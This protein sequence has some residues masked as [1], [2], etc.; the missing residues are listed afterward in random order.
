[1][2]KSRA[3][4]QRAKEHDRIIGT[5]LR[6]MRLAAGMSQGDLGEAL[7]VTFQQ[8]QKY[9][10]GVNRVSGSALLTLC[11]VLKTTPD[12]LLGAKLNGKVSNS[13]TAVDLLDDPAIYRALEAL[14]ALPAER[15]S[16]V[17]RAMMALTAAF[18]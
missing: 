13:I 14:R 7:G 4:R 3:T 12:N 16:A 10:N 2:P 8:I 15:R 5:R 1:M 18:A 11:N 9:E 17:A 6:G